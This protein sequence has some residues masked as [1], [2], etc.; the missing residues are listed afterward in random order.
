MHAVLSA[1]TNLTMPD[2]FKDEFDLLVGTDVFTKVTQVVNAS[3]FQMLKAAVSKKIRATMEENNSSYEQELDRVLNMLNLIG[4]TWQELS[5]VFSALTG[6]DIQ[7]I[8]DKLRAGVQDSAGE[9][10]SIKEKLDS[11]GGS[12]DA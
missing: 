4:Q 2:K 8:I 10:N 6:D 11:A 7:I 1:Y 5:N 3:Q 12:D 9:V